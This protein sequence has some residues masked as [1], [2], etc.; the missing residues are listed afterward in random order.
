M[1]YKAK[2][3]IAW[4]ITI[5]VALPLL[6]SGIFKLI[7]FQNPDT[8]LT[9]S[10]QFELWG[11]PIWFMYFIGVAE[12]AGAIGLFIPK[13]RLLAA[14]SLLVIMVGAF[15]THLRAG[16]GEF[17]GALVLMILLVVFLLLRKG[18]KLISKD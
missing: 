3:I 12:I 16:D 14:M 15:V 13:L 6:G 10:A 8:N 1:S 9:M 18:S 11:Y 5:L 4:V 2:N 17:I 7:D